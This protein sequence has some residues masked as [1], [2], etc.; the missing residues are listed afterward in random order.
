MLN[1]NLTVEQNDHHLLWFKSRSP[2]NNAYWNWV[3]IFQ[4]CFHVLKNG[5]AFYFWRG[6]EKT[7]K[8]K[9]NINFFYKQTTLFHQGFMH[10]C[11]NIKV[12]LYLAQP[13]I[14]RINLSCLV[15]DLGDRK[16]ESIL[17]HCWL[18]S[19]I[20][21]ISPGWQVLCSF[22]TVK[23]HQV[24]LPARI[25]TETWLCLSLWSTFHSIPSPLV[26][27]VIVRITSRE[28]QLW[29]TL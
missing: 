17:L 24:L 26:L 12:N 27:W 15:H 22:S 5:N 11:Q 10:S 6:K 23:C 21:S 1:S 19:K 3:I 13:E 9:R 28:Q 20:S 14:L 8:Y 18:N 29:I 16:N 7:E 25:S 2:L 4:E